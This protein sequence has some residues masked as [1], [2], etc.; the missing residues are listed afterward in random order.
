MGHLQNKVIKRKELKEAQMEELTLIK[1]TE[2]QEAALMAIL[3]KAGNTHI[4]YK[5][6]CLK[7]SKKKKPMKV[8]IETSYEDY[9]K[10][11]D[12][13]TP[14]SIIAPLVIPSTPEKKKDFFKQNIIDNE[15]VMSCSCGNHITLCRSCGKVFCSRC[16]K[17]SRT[18][19]ECP[20]CRTWGSIATVR[21]VQGGL[22]VGKYH[23]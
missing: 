22:R 17:D 20:D 1:E 12:N 6:M 8:S 2:A 7:A 9:R 15:T 4:K 11:C 23:Y 14:A 13:L 21:D 16:R 18:G 5:K 19:N 10:Y 3:E